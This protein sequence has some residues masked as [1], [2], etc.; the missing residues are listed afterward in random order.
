MSIRTFITSLIFAFFLTTPSLAGEFFSKSSAVDNATHGAEVAKHRLVDL[1]NVALVSAIASGEVTIETFNGRK[2][3]LR[4]K[5]IRE[6]RGQVIWTGTGHGVNYSVLVVKDGRLTGAISKGINLYIIEPTGHGSQHRLK[7]ID[8]D[9][10]PL[11]THLAAAKC[12]PKNKNCNGSGGGGSGGGGGVV[13]PPPGTV[14]EIKMLA[15]YTSR[16]ATILGDPAAR[17]AVDIAIIN[18]AFINSQIPMKVTLVGVAAV[19]PTYDE[20]VYSDSTQPIRDLTSGT[21]ANFPALRDLRTSLGADFVTMYADRREYCG[22]A[23]VNTGL[24]AS[25]AFSAINPACSGSLTMAHELGHNMG[26]RHDRYV[27]A[28]TDSTVYNYGY[29]SVEGRFRDIMSYN[30]LCDAA[31]VSCARITYYSN[32]KLFYNGYPLGI[33]QGTEGAAD[34][35][36][37][38][39]EGAIPASNFR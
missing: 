32:S 10:L 17:A 12:P 21:V 15:V 27:E 31:G 1:D 36:R 18:D 34:A 20:T 11:D 19:S 39:T 26:S 23:W 28:V 33:P 35:S 37:K 14:I 13:V 9:K 16:A 4:V 29:V 8:Q 5:R 38:L 24:S 22:I 30:N 2:I 25:Y 7:L 6:V 3:N